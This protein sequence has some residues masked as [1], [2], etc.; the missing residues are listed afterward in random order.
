[1]IDD[2][3]VNILMYH[4]ISDGPGPTCIP[5]K[6]FQHQLNSLQE[7]G[8][9]PISL[10][11]FVACYQGEREFP[12]RPVVI[13]FD[14]G[15]ADFAEN[16]FPELQARGW[17]ATVF[18]PA[19]LMGKCENWQGKLEP[20]PRRLMDWPQVV[21]LSK[22]G[23]DFGGHGMT[24]P[25]MTKLTSQ[26]LQ[27]ETRESREVIQRHLG[28]SPPV[29]FAPPYGLSNVIVRNEIRKWYK[30]SV[31]V[32]FRRADRDCDLYDVPRIEMHY[33]RNIKRWNSF[34]EG[35]AEAYFAARR[36]LRNIRRLI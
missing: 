36:F 18:L 8:Y 35:R 14:D 25:D 32:K 30:V 34:L 21:E 31:G 6:T 33:F 26:E 16:A 11:N 27:H 29:S 1:M 9:Q 24:H 4:S 5:L 23:I 20:T 13:T 17:P 19:G 2:L 15:F 22:Q 7:H 28:G 10:A 3:G 12:S